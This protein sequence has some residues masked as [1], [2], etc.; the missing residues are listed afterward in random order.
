MK[1]IPLPTGLALLAVMLATITYLVWRLVKTQRQ[2]SVSLHSDLE[3]LGRVGRALVEFQFDL[4]KLYELI[5][6]QAGVV[7]DTTTFQLGLFEGDDYH[8]V[9][10]VKEGVR[11]QPAQFL[12]ARETGLVGWVAENKQNV[13]I[14]DFESEWS[15]LPARPQY[16]S[17]DPPKSAIF[18][19]LITGDECIG[20]MAAQSSQADMFSQDDCQRLEILA[21]QAASAIVTSRLYEQNRARA[22]QLEIVS[23]VAQRVRALLPLQGF[24]AHVVDLVHDS[25]HYYCVNILIVNPKDHQVT[26]EASSSTAFSEF[27]HGLPTDGGLINWALDHQQAV[28]V[29]DVGEDARYTPTTVLPETQSEMVVPLMVENEMLGV[30]D[31]QSN[32]Q[33]AFQPLDQFVMEILAD[34]LALAIQESRLFDAEQHQRSVAETLQRLSQ[35]LTSSLELDEVLG[36]ILK[37]LGLV[38]P[39]DAAAI[40]LTENDETLVVRAATGF[41]HATQVQ[42]FRFPINES[43]RFQM[44]RES[45]QPMIFDEHDALGCFHAAVGLESEHSCLGA[46]LIARGEVIGYLTVDALPPKVFTTSEADVLASFAGQAA[47]AIENARLYDA[48]REE[49]WVSNALLEMVTSVAPATD[50]NTAVETIANMTVDIMGIEQCGVLMWNKE[51]ELFQ[52]ARIA[53]G[54]S[55]L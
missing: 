8:I 48:Q 44:L 55:D 16:L 14:H 32:I 15:N 40:L 38:I 39:N 54:P 6:E 36:E 46:P 41:A 28:V 22:A 34:Q 52:G 4:S 3:A 47:I 37:G 53:G 27:F 43:V 42:G 18:V 21:N 20:V 17:P 13:V 31:I 10:W 25:F 1:S 5:L 11:Q 7:I 24:L 9:V 19:P 2:G 45:L 50:P 49:A 23:R 12:N 29:N 33:R 30:L 51:R 26:L 35:T